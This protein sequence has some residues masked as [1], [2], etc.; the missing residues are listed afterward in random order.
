[1]TATLPP[2]VLLTIRA[3]AC[4]T[5]SE[6]S[7]E[8][9]AAR[10]EVPVVRVLECLQMA[11]DAVRLLTRAGNA[12]GAA[13][14]LNDQ[15]ALYVRLGDPVRA[16]YLLE[17]VRTV[18]ENLATSDSTALREIAHADH[19][20][21]RL[22]LHTPARTGREADALA[23]ARER[24]LVAQEAYQQ[25]NDDRSLAR[26]WETLGRID[27]RA[28]R[29]ELAEKHLNAAVQV[30]QSTDDRVGLARS[31]AALAEVFASTGRPAEALHSLAESVTLNLE[32]GSP[33]GLAFNRRNLES[34]AR[35][36]DV[37]AE[38]FAVVA[39]RL[40]EAEKIVGPSV[41]PDALA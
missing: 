39:Q 7:A 33:I 17:Q 10:L 37:P 38:E 27:L 11:S 15:A 1:M 23:M 32:K 3:A 24:A 18:F 40:A 14:L 26:V 30:Q 4:D 19:L 9:V 28:N 31:T 12:T 8:R 41:I 6:F 29:P 35:G 2:T 21:A 13:R 20:L 5:D 25:L 34:F 22:L 16:A 36:K